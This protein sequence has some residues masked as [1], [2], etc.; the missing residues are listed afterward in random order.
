VALAGASQI[1][2]ICDLVKAVLEQVAVR[3]EGHRGRPVTE[4]LLHGGG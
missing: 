1:H 3:V 2:R 4:H